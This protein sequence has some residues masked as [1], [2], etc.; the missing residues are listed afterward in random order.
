M[1]P[2]VYLAGQ[3]AGLTYGDAQDW[4][5]HVRAVL[6]VHG[7]AAFSPLRGK[8]FLYGAGVLESSVETH[9]L[10]TAKGLTARDREDVRRADAVLMY[11]PSAERISIGTMIEI[12]WADAWRVPIVL[13]T[14]PD[15]AY[16]THPM[17]KECAA[18]VVGDL[19]SAVSIL[20][21]LLLP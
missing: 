14:P 4:R 2:R 18:Y 6:S 8:D 17:V 12:G 11:L 21:A 1:T 19:Q 5:L 9:P 7:I 15:S 13:V 16:A 20:S 3:I 10:S